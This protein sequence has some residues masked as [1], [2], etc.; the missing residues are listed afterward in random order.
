M[1]GLASTSEIEFIWSSV[2]SE[3]STDNSDLLSATLINFF[4]SVF[5]NL[6]SFFNEPFILQ[7][8]NILFM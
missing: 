4:C 8:G 1:Q 5:R 7:L 6:L 3:N 2:R